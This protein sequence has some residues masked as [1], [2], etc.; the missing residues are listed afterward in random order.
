MSATCPNLTF[1]SNRQ[2]LSNN[3]FCEKKFHTT[4]S[5]LILLAI[6]KRPRKIF[7]VSWYFFTSTFS[8]VQDIGFMSA[9]T[10]NL[11]IFYKI[12]ENESFTPYRPLP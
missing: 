7:L 8:R 5:F 2:K 3:L 11:K 9:T 12:C 6:K 10:T 4:V 1:C